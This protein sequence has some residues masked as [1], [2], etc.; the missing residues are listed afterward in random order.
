MIVVCLCTLDFVLVLLI[1]SLSGFLPHC[2]ASTSTRCLRMF[3]FFFAFSFVFDRFF[4]KY[5]PLSYI[6]SPVCLLY[7]RFCFLFSVFLRFVLCFFLR[8]DQ[9]LYYGAMPTLFNVT[10]ANGM[11]VTGYITSLSWK[12][13]IE[14][15]GDA[16]ESGGDV[17]KLEADYPEVIWPWSG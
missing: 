17:L 6:A 1:F 13:E 4:F 3:A 8:D 12:E 7:F 14:P 10:I 5:S 16:T 9:A 11:G 15:L 2:R